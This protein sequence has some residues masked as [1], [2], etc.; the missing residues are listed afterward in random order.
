M[1]DALGNAPVLLAL[2]K[3]MEPSDRDRVV[4]RASIVAT[5]V[6][7]VFAF[8][9][10]TILRYLHISLGSLEAAGGLILLLVALD[11]LRGE[12]ESPVVEQERDVAITPLALPLLAGPGTLSTVMI[13]MADAPSFHVGVI[14]GTLAAML[15]T[16]LIMRQASRVDRWIGDQGAIIITK[17]SGFLL[18]ALAIEVGSQGIREL[19]HLL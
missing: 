11:M 1:A 13:L 9:G 19:F 15:V 6:I 2:T 16:W 7:L 12:L 3:E 18:A 14:A 4:D 17:L 5:I 8:A 10:Q